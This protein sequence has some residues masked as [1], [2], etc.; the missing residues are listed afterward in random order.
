M[1]VPQMSLPWSMVPDTLA[2]PSR[3][4]TRTVTW[5]ARLGLVKGNTD[6]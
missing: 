4:V 6:C 5:F 3:I 1:P 2:L